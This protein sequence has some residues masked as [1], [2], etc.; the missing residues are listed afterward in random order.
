MS[1]RT[2]SADP[3]A[4][5]DEQRPLGIDLPK[6]TKRLIIISAML[7]MFMASLEQSVVNPAMPQIVSELGGLEL[8]PWLVQ[9]F[10]MAQVV[11]IPVAGTLSDIYGRKPV[12]LGGLIIFLLGSA[13]CG[14]AP[15][16]YE[17]IAFRA[18]QGVGAAILMTATFSVVGDLYLPADRGRFIGLFGGVFALSGLIGAPLGGVLTE[19]LSWRW[20]FWVMLALG[21]IVLFV[22]AIKMPWLRPPP[23]PFRL[24]IKGVVL[25]TTALVPAM[26]SLSLAATWGWFAPQTLAL[27]AVSIAAMYL[28]FRVERSAEQPIVPLELFKITTVAT[29]AVVNFFLGVGMMGVFVYLQFYLQVGLGADAATAGLVMGPM[30]LVSVFASVVSGQVMSRTGRYKFL[31]V[32]G[33]LMMFS[34]MLLLSTMTRDTT[35]P[36]VLGRMFLFG[37]GMGLM[38]PVMS[39]A[40]QNA[41]PQKYLGIVSAFTQFFQQ[42]GGVIGIGVIGALFNARLASGLAER[43]E[44]D[45]ADRVQ[46]EKLVDPIFR[47]DLMNDL[48]PEVWTVAEPQV[49]AAVATAITDNFLL[50]AA[51]VF[52]SVL[53]ILRMKEIRLRREGMPAAAV[54]VERPEPTRAIASRPS[55]SVVSSARDIPISTRPSQPARLNG[56]SEV[57]ELELRAQLRPPDEPVATI[58]NESV[59]SMRRS[60]VAAA[61]LGAGVGFALSFVYPRN[62]TR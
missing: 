45:V 57:F 3:Q 46:P 40:S 14:F 58:S 11:T 52:I 16:I 31:A 13:M 55:G 5:P 59:P 17:L 8:Y 62:R 36:G 1:V 42:V 26:I 47:E 2:D 60:V 38:M 15:G 30:I 49:Q 22:I 32:T 29:T 54:A 28:F 53:A 4:P 20:V 18:V 34:S 33:S 9:A 41:S 24:D 44:P 12:L 61:M 21:P 35:I 7:G 50:A 48:G 6:R 23:K 25:L 19:T 27:F 56:V 10:I 37:I 39:I 51:I 43:L